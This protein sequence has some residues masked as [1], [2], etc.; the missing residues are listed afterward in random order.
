MAPASIATTEPGRKTK[1]RSIRRDSVGS[2]GFFVAEFPRGM[3]TSTAPL[4]R[5]VFLARVRADQPQEPK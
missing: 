3:V 2:P 1:A 5:R 4:Y